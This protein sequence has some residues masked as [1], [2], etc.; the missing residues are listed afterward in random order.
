[1]VCS[2]FEKTNLR[3]DKQC[4]IDCHNRL[5][6]YTSMID[7][8]GIN[9]RTPYSIIRRYLQTC[10]EERRHGDSNHLI[11]DDE[12]R[13][14]M[15]SIVEEY[16]E[17][18]TDQMNQESRLRLPERRQVCNH[19][20]S[21]ILHCRLITLTLTHDSQHSGIHQRSKISGGIWQTL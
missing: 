14:M 21:N 20:I 18:T 9:R 13:D 12:M 5:D 15:L 16:P 2:Y 10:D 6:D 3:R 7:A 19:T 4:I 11:V 17:F 8:L 1:M